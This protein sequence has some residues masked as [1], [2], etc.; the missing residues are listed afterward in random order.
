MIDIIRRDT[1][2]FYHIILSLGHNWTPVESQNHMWIVS[3]F[4]GKLDTC[5]DYGRKFPI[6]CSL[7][8]Q[9]P[10][11]QCTLSPT[12]PSAQINP[13]STTTTYP[14]CALSSPSSYGCKLYSCSPGLQVQTGLDGRNRK[15]HPPRNSLKNRLLSHPKTFLS[16]FVRECSEELHVPGKFM[17]WRTNS[18]LI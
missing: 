5:P 3:S 7:S 14:I 13:H 10:T 15:D 9:R 16:I 6:T 2:T 4:F 12:C 17:S 1:D 11:K 8:S 18:W